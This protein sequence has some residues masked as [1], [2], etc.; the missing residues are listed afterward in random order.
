MERDQCLCQQKSHTNTFYMSSY[1]DIGYVIRSPSHNAYILLSLQ[2]SI[3]Q[4]SKKYKDVNSKKNS[5]RSG[6]KINCCSEITAK[7]NDVDKKAG[8]NQPLNT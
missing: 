8:R 3:N 4:I 1:N 7:L 6:K 2:A 5:I